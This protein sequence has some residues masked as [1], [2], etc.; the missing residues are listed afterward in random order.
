MQSDMSEPEETQYIAQATATLQQHTG[1]TPKGWLGPWIS[2][3]FV[4][5]DLLQVNSLS[6]AQCMQEG[7]TL[8]HARGWHIAKT[9]TAYM[10][11]VLSWPSG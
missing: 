11:L 1:K 4:T 5:P 2:E 3:S 10:M 7:F 9:I 6:C 8:L